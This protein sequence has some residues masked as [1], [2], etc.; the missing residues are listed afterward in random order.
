MNLLWQKGKCPFWNSFR[1]FFLF[2]VFWFVLLFIIF[3]NEQKRNKVVFI[4]LVTKKIIGDMYNRCAW[5]V[6]TKKQFDIV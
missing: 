2:L 6:E 4:L 5:N 3:I 1:E